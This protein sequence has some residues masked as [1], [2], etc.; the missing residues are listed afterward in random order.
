MRKSART[1]DFDKFSQRFVRNYWDTI[2]QDALD[3]PG[4]EPS[5]KSLE[6]LLSEIHYSISS[7][8]GLFTLLMINTLGDIWR[9]TFRLHKG[10]WTI[11]SA[12]SG[13][14][15]NHA[16]V[17]WLDEVYSPWFQPF[18]DKLVQKSC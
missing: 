4:S 5:E 13:N 9:F 6:E 2:A 17:N 15:E 14:P 16:L 18:L 7:E 10:R 3:L 11:H 12:T 1:P 8:H